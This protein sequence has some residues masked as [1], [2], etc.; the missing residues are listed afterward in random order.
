MVDFGELPMRILRVDMAGLQVRWEE[1]PAAYEHL[2]GRS[3][4]A[5]ILLDEVEPECDSLGPRNKLIVAPG[6]LGGA[7]VTTAGRLSI[8]AKSPL[9][10][11]SKRQMPAEPRATPSEGSA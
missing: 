8:G 1:V 7:G 4:I 10:R 5:R 3:L 2:G 11:E 6:L 9:T